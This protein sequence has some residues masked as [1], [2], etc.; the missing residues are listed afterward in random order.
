V[1][2]ARPGVQEE[3]VSAEPER[4]FRPPVSATGTF[5]GWL[6][7]FL[8]TLGEN[9]VDWEEIAA[10]LTEAYR[11]VAPMKLIAELEGRR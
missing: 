1:V 5:S 3:P 8:D 10:I 4:F 7:V 2:P 6:G 9:N 11:Y